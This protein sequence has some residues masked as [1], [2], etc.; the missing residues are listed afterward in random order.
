MKEL[1]VVDTQQCRDKE[2]VEN[3]GCDGVE[4]KSSKKKRFYELFE[5]F[6]FIRKGLGPMEENKTQIN[7][8]SLF[9]HLTRFGKG[10]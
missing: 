5:V 9:A 10:L 6:L 8:S 7:S 3:C 2:G 4:N 1:L